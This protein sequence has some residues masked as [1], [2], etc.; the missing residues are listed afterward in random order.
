M[1]RFLF[2]SL[3]NGP[4]V[5]LVSG[6]QLVNRWDLPLTAAGKPF[7]YQG[8]IEVF[9]VIAELTGLLLHCLLCDSATRN[10]HRRGNA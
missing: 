6:G 8:Q 3:R 5:A 4:D 2:S 10:T 9:A 7:P 1:A